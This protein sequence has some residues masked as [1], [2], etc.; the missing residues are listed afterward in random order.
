MTTLAALTV[1]L[2]LCLG[3]CSS[4]ATEGPAAID[5]GAPGDATPDRVGSGDTSET[6]E[7]TAAEASSDTASCALHKPYSTKNAACNACAQARCCAVLNDCFDDLRCDDDY[8][9]CI[10]ACALLPADAGPD[11]GDATGACLADCAAKHPAG[12]TRYD[13][14]IACVDGTCAAECR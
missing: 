11:A 6:A 8:V 9:N 5:T 13:A 14:A 2:S 12:K 7:A 4:S 1:A 10:L 3:A